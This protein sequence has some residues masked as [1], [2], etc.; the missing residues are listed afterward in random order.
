VLAP[1]AREN[2]G[3]ALRLPRPLS[4]FAS[5]LFVRSRLDE[6]IERELRDINARERENVGKRAEDSSDA[7]SISSNETDEGF[8]DRLSRNDIEVGLA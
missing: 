3:N 4:N 6:I 7:T 8:F 2:P 5:S 1:F